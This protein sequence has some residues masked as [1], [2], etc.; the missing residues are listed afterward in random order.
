MVIAYKFKDSTVKAVTHAS[1][2]LT[3]TEKCYRQIEKEA[4]A[5]IFA[6]K[7]FPTMILGKK[8]ILKTDHHPLLSISSSKKGIP[9]HTAN[10]LQCWGMILLNYDFKMEFLSSKRL[11][12]AEGLF[13]L[14]LKCKEDFEGT[15][16]ASVESESKIKSLVCNTIKEL[17]VSTDDIKIHSKKDMFIE[18]DYE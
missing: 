17:P 11:G 15:V 3:N 6:V 16:I 12:H 18:K 7:E 10:R 1:R 4:F 9:M 2:S 14:I 5:I 13:R 8:S